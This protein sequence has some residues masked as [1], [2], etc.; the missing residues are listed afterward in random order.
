ML[1][2]STN[3]QSPKVGFKEATIQ[4]QAPDKGLYFP[5]K[6]PLLS[7]EFLSSFRSWSKQAIAFQMIKPYVGDAMPPVMLD[8]IVNETLNFDFPLEKVDENIFTLEL[9]HGPFLARCNQQDSKKIW[10]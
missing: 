8:K 5:E 4:G 7:K 9:F 3:K 1:Y 2:Y 10:F 6:I